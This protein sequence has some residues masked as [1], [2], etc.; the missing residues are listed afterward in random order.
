MKKGDYVLCDGI[1]WKV[2]MKHARDTYQIKCLEQSKTY[3]DNME[4]KPED[5]TVVT[6]EVAD[7]LIAVKT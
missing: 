6:K 4:V 3:I 2:W 1:L 5:V 7:I